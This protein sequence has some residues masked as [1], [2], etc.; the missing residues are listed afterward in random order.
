M[1]TDLFPP[2]PKMPSVSRELF[3]SSRYSAC[4]TKAGLIVQSHRTGTGRLLAT[5]H[6]QYADYVDA[7][8]TAID[9]DEANALCRALIQ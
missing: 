7:I 4:I 1:K 3:N 9:T 8:E 5:T 6:P 2:R